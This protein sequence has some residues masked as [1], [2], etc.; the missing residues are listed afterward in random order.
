M[1]LNRFVFVAIHVVMNPPYEPPVAPIFVLSTS[2][3]AATM[4]TAFIRSW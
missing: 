3:R 1:A 2:G 4:S